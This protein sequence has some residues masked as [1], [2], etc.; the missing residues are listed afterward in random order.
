MDKIVTLRKFL[1]TMY[2]DV[3]FIVRF[4]KKT[5]YE[6]IVK[7]AAMI[8]YDPI[9]GIKFLKLKKGKILN[10]DTFIGEINGFYPI[11]TEDNCV[12]KYM[13]NEG[14]YILNN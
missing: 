1:K 6:I 12:F 7:G 4:N 11:L 10:V 8:D 13:T 9:D 5:K 3:N 14:T 2:P